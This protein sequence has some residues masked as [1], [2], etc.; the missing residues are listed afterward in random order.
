MT[1]RPGY[2]TVD[3]SEYLD[4]NATLRLKVRAV[5][6]LLSSSNTPVLY[7]GAGISTASGIG[8]YA[9]EAAG[10]KS[11]IHTAKRVLPYSAQPTLAHRVFA[12]LSTDPTVGLQ[13]LRW[14][15]QN[16]DGTIF[17]FC[18]HPY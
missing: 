4:S 14:V 9:S 17:S 18:V 10:T 5:A 16:H 13:Q 8:D 7:T 11:L 12:A 1:A 15:Q 3:S 2:A 6:E